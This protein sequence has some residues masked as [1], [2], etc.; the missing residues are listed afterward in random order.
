MGARGAA[1]GGGSP[2]RRLG[3]ASRAGVKRGP[4][5]PSEL[6]CVPPPVS[7]RASC[8]SFGCCSRPCPSTSAALFLGHS[9]RGPLPRAQPAGR[10]GGGRGLPGAPRP[11][12]PPPLRPRRPGSPRSRPRTLQTVAC[13]AA[14]PTR[15]SGPRASGPK[16]PARRPQGRE[17]SQGR[18]A[19]ASSSS[20][21]FP[22]SLRSWSRSLDGLATDA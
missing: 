8:L 17:G 20:A 3:R 21:L 14:L 7:G 4:L 5:G 19:F 6:P 22:G 2:G 16:F 18:E 11:A 15:L 1:H 10:R 12:G 9:L 13:G